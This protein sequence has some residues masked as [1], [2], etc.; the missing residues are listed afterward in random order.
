MLATALSRRIGPERA[1][2]G[3][4]ALGA[5]AGCAL[6]AAVAPD[7][8][9]PYPVCPTRSLFD[10]DCPA[11]GTLR[12]LHALSRGQ[13]G[14]AVS[15]NVLLLVAVPIGAAMWLCWA[16]TAVGRPLE[17]PA[18]PR[19]AVP[20]LLLAGVVFTVVRNLPQPAFAWLGS[21]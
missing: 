9:G 1:A 3:A 8:D 19:W 11:C 18:V 20:A 6:V 14:A 17:P 10:I 5:L 16:A 2:S 13:V 21:S 4:L 7:P 12:G 15:H